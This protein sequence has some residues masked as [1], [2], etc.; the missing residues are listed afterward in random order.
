LK[1]REVEIVVPGYFAFMYL[2]N[3]LDH[4]KETPLKTLS[5]V[6]EYFY[7]TGEIEPT[8]LDQQEQFLF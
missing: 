2:K 7:R 3:S 1:D 5:K 8:P 6:R 4:I